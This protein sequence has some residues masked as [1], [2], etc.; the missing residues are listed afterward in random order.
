MIYTIFLSFIKAHYA[1]FGISYCI[2]ERRVYF[3]DNDIFVVV[4]AVV[5]FMQEETQPVDADELKQ[6]LMREKSAHMGST[7]WNSYLY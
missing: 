2:N 7:G 4:L 1:L 5:F 3:N 6:K